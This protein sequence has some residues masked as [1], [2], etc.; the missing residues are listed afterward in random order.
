MRVIT[1][2]FRSIGLMFA[3]FLGSGRL[4]GLLRL[5]VVVGMVILFANWGRFIWNEPGSKPA[6]LIWR[7]GLRFWVMPLAAILG[8]ILTGSQFVKR[9]HTLQLQRLALR[10]LIASAFSFNVPH[11]EVKDGRPRT[12]A[13]QD[14][15]LIIIGGPG[16]VNVRPGS[17][18][19]VET[20]HK[21]TR[22]LGAG[23]YLLTRTER[24]REIISLADQHG[25]TEQVT[26][27]TKDGVEINAKRV[28]YR[29]RLQTGRQPRDYRKRTTEDPYPFSPHAAYKLAYQRSAFADSSL[30]VWDRVVK[31]AVDGVVT[32]YLN[33]NKFD[34]ATTPL[35]G[36][37]PRLA[38]AVQMNA[39][40]VRDRLRNIG[41]ELLWFDIGEFE[42]RLAE[43]D[44]QRIVTWGARWSGEAT[45]EA[46]KGDAR[47]I[48]DEEFARAEAQA[49]MLTAITETLKDAGMAGDSKQ[50]LRQMIV[51]RTAQLLETMVEAN[52]LALDRD[53][54]V[55]PPSVTT[56]RWM[57]ED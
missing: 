1:I 22:V 52:R 34:F 10:Y 28:N 49:E 36:G 3:R 4:W 6:S 31:I 48:S 9:L 29:Y 54:P 12:K 57:R 30:T 53:L 42:P 46:A 17:A 38:M 19:V 35:S 51:I 20:L 44:L 56:R 26:A 41:T 8:A 11:L 14:N 55:Q 25:M 50:N 45:V 37:D 5:A 7:W 15:P 13:G 21:P 16:Y 40:S 27:A 2:L 24:V 43:I 33:T 23:L 18:V 47:R 39:K 32:D